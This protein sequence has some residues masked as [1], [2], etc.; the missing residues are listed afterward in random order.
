MKKLLTFI[1][2]VLLPSAVTAADLSS[3]YEMAAANDPK[4][5]AARASREADAYQVMIARSALLPRASA[6]YSQ[7]NIEIEFENITTEQDLGNLAIN[8]GMSL[9]NLNGWYTFKAAK[10]LDDN[11]VYE[12]Q[13][14]EQQLLLHTAESYFNALRAEDNLSTADAEL[15]AVQ[16]S[17]EQTKQRYEVGLTAIT[18]VHSAQAAY[19]LSYAKLLGQ[20]AN[21]QIQYEILEQ[22]TGQT[23][24]EISTLKDEVNMSRP[25]PADPNIW[26]DSGMNKFPGLQMIDAQLDAAR[27]QRNAARAAHLPTVELFANYEDGDQPTTFQ[28]ASPGSIGIR[29]TRYGVSVS[30]PLLTG[31]S[32]YAQ[33]KQAAL[34][35]AAAGHLVE[36]ERR[37]VRQNIRSLYLQAQTDV[38][39]INA[40]QQVI[41][42]ARSALE[43][44]QT[45]YEVGTRNIVEL[46]DAQ[47]QLYGAERDYANA[48]YDYIINLLTLKYYAGTLNEADLAMLNNWLSN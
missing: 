11:G 27:M 5:A 29:Q 1:A 14:A 41:R 44:T 34:N 17:L 26:V 36:N 25:E 10:A 33:T 21:R 35:Y 40:R 42:S 3:I 23:I 16:R 31:G 47:Q 24:S 46:L 48:R 20:Q 12:L 13:M 45:G 2:A 6:S 38:L 15:Q 39:N 9:F 4:I 30:I 7:T 22:L 19:D 37:T 28:T 32:L 8:A 18:D 43:T